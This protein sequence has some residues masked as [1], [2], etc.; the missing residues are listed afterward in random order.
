VT[1]YRAVL[2]LAFSVS[3]LGVLTGSNA[4][5]Q[6]RATPQDVWLGTWTTANYQCVLLSDG[7]SA[8]CADAEC[9]G[10]SPGSITFSL[11]G[12]KI[13]GTVKGVFTG[14]DLSFTGS[15]SA[16]SLSGSWVTGSEQGSLNLT[17]SSGSTSFSGLL[18]WN[19][20]GI[21]RTTKLIGSKTAGVSPTTTK[22][23]TT[24]TGAA[25]ALMKKF[26]TQFDS[27]GF[28]KA[29][30]LGALKIYSA[31]LAGLTIKV[32]PNLTAVALYDPDSKS[33]T[34]SRDPRTISP[35]DLAAGETVWQ[36]RSAAGVQQ[37][38]ETTSLE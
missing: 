1:R 14:A 13:I 20:M 31:T 37:D 12:S 19:N 15:G 26:M 5:A 34:F 35:N 32:D 7:T 24:L 9:K 21:L 28:A 27:Y 38:N 3:L 23:A 17:M 6:S 16:T 11:S 29:T 22:P 36:W 33:I 25:Y 4:R 2:V 30:D 8:C 18:T 10:G